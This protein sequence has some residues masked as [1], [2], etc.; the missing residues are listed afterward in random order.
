MNGLA[1]QM[2]GARGVS[3]PGGD[4]RSLAQPPVRSTYGQGAPLG[5]P[6]ATPQSTITGIGR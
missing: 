4:M 3:F 5:P 6:Q 2:H 1:G